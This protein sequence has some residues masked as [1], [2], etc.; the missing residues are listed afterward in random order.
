MSHSLNEIEAHAKRAARGAG[1]SWGMAEEAAKAARWL[2]SHDLAGP[3]LLSEVLTQNDG[4]THAQV[5]PA[6]LDGEW[7][8]PA[9]DLCPL[10]AGAALND[11]A[12]RLVA[13]Q[14]IEM[15]NVSYPLLILPF[16][17]W[18]ALHI[19]QPVR[20]IWQDVQIDTDGD[21]IW[22]QG[23]QSRI[24]TAKVATLFCQ[25]TTG[26]QDA[27]SHPGQRGDVAPD[28]WARLNTF[29]QR[30]YAPATDASRLL[31]AGAGVSDND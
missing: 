12:E 5:A 29:A 14:P 4:L 31:G 26:R 30:T 22:V 24:N 2:A 19:N 6:T 18:V 3:A 21:G 28:I 25:P 8:A 15:T 23:P 16:A 13:G 11:C 7:R 17:A 9:G 1:L 20:V 27:P 10:A